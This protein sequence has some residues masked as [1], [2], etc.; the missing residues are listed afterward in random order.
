MLKGE[1][2]IQEERLKIQGKYQ[3]QGE[4]FKREEARIR[5]TAQLRQGVLKIV[6]AVGM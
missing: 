4:R 6:P 3:N 1:N 5:Q 2:Q